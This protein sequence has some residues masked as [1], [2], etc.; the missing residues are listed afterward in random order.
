[1]LSADLFE[2]VIVHPARNSRHAISAQNIDLVDPG[3]LVT[4]FFVLNRSLDVTLFPQE[5]CALSENC[6]A[7]MCAPRSLCCR[8]N[9]IAKGLHEPDW[10]KCVID[11]ECREGV[12]D[13]QCD[14][15]TLFNGD[16]D[17]HTLS[18]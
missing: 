5:I 1:M 3:Q 17:I 13:I 18:L 10:I 11:H 9:E 16:T 15:S 4:E 12:C 7:G 6:D 14:V 2:E 8:R